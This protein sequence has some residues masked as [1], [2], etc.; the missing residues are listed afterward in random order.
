MTKPI[1]YLSSASP[2][3]KELLAQVGIPVVV[4]PA[5]IDE[6]PLPDEQAAHYVE[7]LARA[8]ARAGQALVAA[9]GL[10]ASL[11]L[12]A[13]T[14][15]V[16]DEVI[17]GKPADAAAA[18]TMLAQLSGRSH[19]VLTAVAVVNGDEI[20]ACVVC[21]K[22]GFRQLDEHEIHAYVQ[23]GEPFGKAGS[24]GI[25]GLGAV[26]VASMAGSFS[27]VVGLPLSETVSLLQGLGYP[28]WD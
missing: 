10:S 3:R 23:S 16:L 25:Q 1:L 19:D 4:I 5:D 24:Y 8:K 22:V 13:D 21:S 2:R 15:V 9:Q 7:R 20:A 12:A 27:G 28:F 6:T 14:T 26:L 18:V 11:V 17:F